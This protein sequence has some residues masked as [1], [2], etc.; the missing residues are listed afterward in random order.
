MLMLMTDTAELTKRLAARRCQPFFYLQV[1]DYSIFP[2][3]ARRN[4]R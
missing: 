4:V 1:P 2:I 3:G